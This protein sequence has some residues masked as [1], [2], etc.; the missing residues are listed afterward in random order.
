M[1]IKVGVNTLFLIPGEVGGSE[2]VTRNL[3]HALRT[4]A[5]QTELVLFTN[6]ENHDTFEGYDRILLRVSARSRTWR[7][8]AE[9]SVLVHAA[10]RAGIDILLSLGYTA[11]VFGVLRQAV[12]MYDVQFLAFP[13]DFGRLSRTAQRWLIP[14]IAHRAD[15]ILTGSSFSQREIVER[16]RAPISNV[17]VVPFGVDSVFQPKGGR[18]FSE[19]Y[20]LCVANAYPHKNLRRLVRV[21]DRYL[22]SMVPRLVIVGQPGAGEPDSHPKVTRIHRVDLG[23]LVQLYS[24]CDVFVLPSLYEGFGLPVLEAMAC[25]ARVVTSDCASLPEIALDAATYF[26]PTDEQEMGSVLLRTLQEPADVREEYR[27][28]GFRRAGEFTWDKTAS[29]VLDV[30]RTIV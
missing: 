24:G 3:L 28:R 9:Q 1:A 21:F 17:H 29:R 7:T 4:V 25:G 16:L 5:P 10:R 12:M 15:F 2:T 26:D 27:R 22:S 14:Q 6:L 18:P 19:P 30:I 23:E 20:I 11:P 8:L 13:D